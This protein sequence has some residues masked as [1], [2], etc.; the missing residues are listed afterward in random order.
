MNTKSYLTFAAA[1]LIALCAS[2]GSASAAIVTLTFDEAGISVDDSITTQYA[3]AAIF[4][5]ASADIKL[6]SEFNNPFDGYDGQLVHLQN[7]G[8]ASI[9][10]VTLA[11]SADYL[12]F[13]FRRPSDAGVI[14]LKLFSGVNLV[15]DAGEIGWDP[16]VTPSWIPFEYLGAFGTYDR[17]DLISSNKFVIDNFSFGTQAVPLPAP[18]VLLASALAGLVGI[19]RRTR[20]RA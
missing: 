13:Q 9:A 11:E 5:G 6:A 1:I 3:P 20:V 14:S 15:L 10:S 8:T 2:A 19:C 16:A 17:V 7:T 18:F 12:Q 4:S